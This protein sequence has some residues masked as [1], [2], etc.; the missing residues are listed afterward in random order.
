MKIIIHVLL[1]AVALLLAANIIPGVEV[2]GL[3]TAII[4]AFILGLLNLIIRP[5]LFVLT[6]PITIITFGLFTFVLNALMVLFAA[7]FLEGF[8]V[9]GFLPALL[10]SIFV[11][12]AG[13]IGGRL[14]SD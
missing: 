1:V 10:V 5:I 6:L 7:S 4:S 8:N 13:I 11:S 12:I 3:Y 2:G 9:D 14:N